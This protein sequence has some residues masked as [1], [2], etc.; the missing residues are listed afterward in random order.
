M[1]S[2]RSNGEG[3]IYKN[4][5][6]NRFEGQVSVGINGDGKSVRRKVTGRTR[7]EVAKKMTEVRDRCSQGPGLPSDVT[8]GDWLG[9]W[10]SVVLPTANIAP[11]TRDSYEGLCSWYL[12]PR[13]GRIRLVKL[14]PADVRSMLVAM[15]VDGYS[16]NTQRL[17]RATLRRA[18]R[19]A[20]AEGYVSR[21]VA[22]LTDGVK[23]NPKRG[24]TLTPAD[25]K[26]L[27]SSVAGD[28]IKPALHVLLATGLRRSEVLGLCWTDIDLSVSPA[29][30]Q[31]NHALKREK[32][33]LVF[34]EPKTK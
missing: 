21:N 3:T 26:L 7:A 18:L 10:V 19:V 12:V 22:S 16:P 14:T 31:V 17:A 27:L 30:I 20:E 2:K 15:G 4:K 13:L 28:R 11:A 9:Y 24:K 5:S 23:L 34:G 6:R 33:G 29:T 8:V 32:S 1:T 25:V